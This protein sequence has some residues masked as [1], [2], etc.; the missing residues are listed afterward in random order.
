M[1]KGLLIIPICSSL[2]FASGCLPSNV[3]D[4]IEKVEK[5]NSEK[6]ENAPKSEEDVAPEDVEI[7]DEQKEV[8]EDQDAISKEEAVNQLIEEQKSIE[9][10]LPN[11]KKKF[12][13]EQELS[14]Y[15]SNL[16]YLFHKGDLSG[17]KFYEKAKPHFHEDFL[18]MLPSSELDRVETFE[19]LQYTFLQY[20]PAP[21]ESYEIT[22]ATTNIRGDEGESVRKYITDDSRFIYYLLTMKKVND[23]WFVT[24]DSP[25]PPYEIDPAT[26]SSFKKTGGE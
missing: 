2:L 24:D 3:Q 9:I 13:S 21:I 12:T 25:A 19:I 15:M 16:F 26:E 22:E 6:E 4:E 1:K 7:S 8:I 23:Q 5:E 18:A 17:E 20:L 14:Q 11:E 10:T